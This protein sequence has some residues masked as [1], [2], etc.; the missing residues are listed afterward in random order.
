MTNLI[1]DKTIFV[2]DTLTIAFIVSIITKGN[3]VR[4]IFESVEGR[5]TDKAL[6]LLKNFSYKCIN[7]KE[8]KDYKTP[9][10]NFLGFDQNN[11]FTS[12]KKLKEFR[13][14]IDSIYKEEKGVTYVGPVT[15]A[16]MQSLKCNRENIR[17]IHH[18]VGDY[19]WH[20]RTKH[21]DVSNFTVLRSLRHK[22]GNLI[23]LLVKYYV[24]LPNSLYA[25]FFSSKGYSLYNFN[26]ADVQWVNYEDFVSPEIKKGLKEIQTIVDTHKCVLFCPFH[27]GF[28]REGVNQDARI[29]DDFNIKILEQFLA[30]DEIVLFK[31]HYACYKA[32]RHFTNDLEGIVKERTGN[33]CLDITK[34]I[35]DEIGGALL[36]VE[37]LFSLTNLNKLISAMSAALFNLESEKITKCFCIDFCGEKEVAEKFKK[38]SQEAIDKLLK[39]SNRYNSSYHI[40]D[41]KD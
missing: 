13:R 25:G 8:A 2:I 37:V 3:P 5:T 1:Y 28:T 36:P 21:E 6:R 39:S 38:S 14:K 15:S 10:P 7:I 12:L 31:Y 30:K 11:I 16:I 20:Y 35:P 33:T 19:C 17:Y 40:Y 29:Y 4:C 41:Y 34:M 24:R 22:I 9:D 27:S 23:R 32:N 18:G 26:D